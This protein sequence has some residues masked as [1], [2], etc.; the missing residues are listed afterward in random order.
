MGWKGTVRTLSAMARAAERDAQRRHKQALKEQVSSDAATAVVDWENYIDNLVSIHADIS[1]AIEWDAIA[2]TPCPAIPQQGRVHQE[3]AEKELVNFRPRFRDVLKGGSS[4]LRL[5][6]ENILALAPDRDRKAHE[7]S[8]LEYTNAMNEWESDTVLARRLLANDDAAILEVIEEMQ[9]LTSDS[10]IGSNLTFSISNGNLHAKPEI[11]TDEIVPRFRRKQLAS[12]KLSETKMP[13]S[14]FNELYQD[15]V[16]SVA[17]KVAGD[18][19]RIVPLNQI[20]VTCLSRMLNPQTGHQEKTPILSVQ[21]VRES[22]LHLNLDNV[23]PSD[24][25][26]NFNHEMKFSRTKGFAPIEPLHKGKGE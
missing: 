23:D 11:H 5:R 22:Y 1:E 16:A 19:F 9:S 17:L 24:S 6:L 14:Q 3:Q 18:L 20:F 15:Y 21:F 7:D 2:A 12:G 25:M 8:L 4:K 13:Q 10:L 26:R